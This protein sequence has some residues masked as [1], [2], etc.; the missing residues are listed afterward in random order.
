MHHAASLDVAANLRKQLLKQLTALPTEPPVPAD[1]D[2]VAPRRRAW[3]GGQH[4]RARHRARPTPSATDEPRLR[5]A[6][7]PTTDKAYDVRRTITT[8]VLIMMAAEGRLVRA[9]P[10]GAWLAAAHLGAR[11]PVVARRHRA[12][13]PTPRRRL[14]ELYL[15]RFGPVTE[16]DVAWWTGWPLGATRSALAQP[17]TRSTSA[18]AW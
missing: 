18:A 12:G 9:A 10:L 2:G 7:L 15:R 13:R 11:D 14:V 6:I 16:T 8:Q 5:T 1:V 17:P 3:R 4:R